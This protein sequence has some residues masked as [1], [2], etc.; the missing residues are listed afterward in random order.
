MFL[1]ASDVYKD[2]IKSSSAFSIV[3]IINGD[4]CVHYLHSGELYRFNDGAIVSGPIETLKGCPVVVT[5]K[6]TKSKILFDPARKTYLTNE[7]PELI[8]PSQDPTMPLRQMGWVVVYD[9][10]KEKYCIHNFKGELQIYD[11]IPSMPV[12]FTNDLIVC[13]DGI[14]SINISRK[15]FF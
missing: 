14:D 11:Y 12:L 8:F 4:Y 13:A 6:Y 3:K 9:Q 10:K 2:P 5:D 15:N 7:S 1:E